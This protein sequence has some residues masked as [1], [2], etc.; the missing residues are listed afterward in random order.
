MRRRIFLV[1]LLFV[2]VVAGLSAYVTL[3]VATELRASRLALTGAVENPARITEAREHLERALARLDS[4]P[5]EIVKWVPVVGQNLRAVE[6]VARAAAPVVDNG[7][8]LRKQV[9]AL[10]GGA[11]ISDGRVNLNAIEALTQP[12]DDQATS[13]VDLRDELR[14][15]RSGWLLPPLW[16]ELDEALQEVTSLADST[17]AAADLAGM[18]GTMLGAE[19]DRTY[20]VVLLNNAEL[21][22][23]GGIPSGIG[24]LRVRDGNLELGRFSYFNELSG[25]PPYQR[26]QAPADFTRRFAQYKAD[27][28]LWV[29]TTFSPDVPDVALVTSRLYEM[30]TGVAADGVIFADPRGVAALTPPDATLTVPGTDE[31]VGRDALPEYVYWRAY[32]RFAGDNEVRRDVLLGLG[33]QAFRATIEDGLG[34]ADAFGDLGAAAAG[35]HLR[36][37]SFDKE[38]ASALGDAGALGDLAEPPGDAVFVTVDNFGGDKLDYWVDRTVEHNCDI[39]PERATC[40]TVVTL[41]NT[42]R[43][44]LPLYIAGLPYHFKNAEYGLLRSFVEVYKPASADVTAVRLDGED[45]NWFPDGEEGNVAIGIEMRVPQGERSRLSVVY[46]LPLDDDGYRLIATPQP[47]AQDATL[48]VDLELPTGWVLRGDA[49]DSASTFDYDDSFEGQV[50]VTARPDPRGG[51]SGLWVRLKRFWNEPVF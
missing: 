33:E 4:T 29:N 16:D 9:D 28:D 26:V 15:Q 40:E 41:D 39:E 30:N 34:G 20:L 49:E 24:T 44:G 45:S 46:E 37:V 22:G 36:F 7:I 17:R 42:V 10:E 5:A 12:L 14:V 3:S 13:L 43:D 50:D 48:R 11:L 2:L 18:S 19:G 8:E 23:A 27:T 51:L 25:G 21:R 32:E 1:G 47:L 35:G 38:E 6:A 31:S